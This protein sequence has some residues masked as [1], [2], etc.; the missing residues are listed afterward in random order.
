VSIALT[1]L[2]ATPPRASP[3]DP[4]WLDFFPAGR[5]AA[6]VSLTIDPHPETWDRAFALYDRVERV[7]PAR[8][9]LAP[10]R[11]RLNLLAAG[12]GFH[13]EADLWPHLRGLSA[14]LLANPEGQVDG[15]LIALHLSD[16][17]TALRMARDDL[18]RLAR[19]VGMEP[20]KVDGARDGELG[21]IA[22]RPLSTT[23][24][25]TTILIGWGDHAL[26]IAL[27]ADQAARSVGPS[28]RALWGTG[29][30]ERLGAIW[31]RL[32]P[33]LPQAWRTALDGSP[34][35]LWRGVHDAKT[36]RDE[37]IWGHLRKTIHRFL[38]HLPYKAPAA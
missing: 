10:A 33:N 8:A 7:D 1:G 22:G 28:L 36:T 31:P 30:P 35:I 19:V 27:K 37:I 20:A 9:K 3:I 26:D 34:P 2:F 23:C 21:T 13:P 16:E 38:A 4:S 25:G 11:T 29:P 14:A 15:A 18:P 12:A 32:F 17:A 24:Q 5:T 6:V